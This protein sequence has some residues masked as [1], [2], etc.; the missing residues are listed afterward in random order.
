[1]TYSS[2]GLIEAADYNTFVGLNSTTSGTF[3]YIWSTGNGQFGYGQ[4]ALSAV[5]AGA[6]VTAT[7]AVQW[8]SFINGLNNV[9]NHQS[10]VGTG[11]TAPTAGNIIT[12]LNTVSGALSTVITNKALAATR[13]STTTGTVFNDTFSRASSETAYNFNFTRTLTF[14]SGNA[15]R[16]FFNAGGRI[17][18]VVSSVTNVDGAGRSAD[19]TTL[20]GTNFASV[21]NIGGLTN[22]GRSGT[23]GIVN[24]NNTSL[25]YWT[26]S[27][28]PAVISN[29]TST[30]YPYSGDYTQLSI[31]TSAANVAGNGDN[32]YVVYLNL[33]VYLAALQSNFNNKQFSVVINNR[34]D[35]QYPESTYLTSTWGTP[36]VT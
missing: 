33:Y 4:T 14:A 29:I 3:N 25:G 21:T 36:T 28:T 30:N 13:G 11:I 35:I 22:S 24:T 20:V 5:S 17:N 2:G 26:S 9:N 27:T 7:G 23:G 10:G 1:M 19:I 8:A 31:S 32:G 16:Y 12:Y 34:I 6:T 18:F 15:A